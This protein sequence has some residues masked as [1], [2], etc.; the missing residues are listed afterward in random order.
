MLATEGGM[1]NGWT[2]HSLLAARSPSCF[3]GSLGGEQLAR[4]F[5]R[6]SLGYLFLNVIDLADVGK[7]VKCADGSRIPFRAP[8]LGEGFTR[9]WYGEKYWPC[10]EPP[11]GEMVAINV[12]TGDIAWKSPAGR[13]R[14]V[15]EQGHPGHRHVNIGGSRRLP[16]VWCLSAPPTTR[17]FRAF[18]AKTGKVLWEHQLEAGAYASPSTYQ[19]KD[20]RQYVV[21]V[22]TGG[23]YYDRVSGDSV[24][25]SRCHR[26]GS[27]QQGHKWL[28][29]WLLR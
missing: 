3:P 14:R 27:D 11:W 21:V 2:V 28:P 10:Q 9:F 24:V 15:G 20:G 18:D 26:K 12:N 19:G 8:A 25:T 5:V 6:P 22:T 1:H 4:R 16:E 29:R 17:R 23:G 7:V 13:H